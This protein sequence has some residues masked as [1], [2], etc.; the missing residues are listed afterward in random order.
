MGLRIGS[1]LRITPIAFY[2]RHLIA[3]RFK[4]GGASGKD[5]IAGSRISLNVDVIHS[6]PELSGNQDGFAAAMRDDA[7]F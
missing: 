5:Q 4:V 2:R 6:E 3:F 1:A 7:V